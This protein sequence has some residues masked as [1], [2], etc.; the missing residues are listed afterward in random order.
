MLLL[1]DVDEY[2]FAYTG[3][4]DGLVLKG[5]NPAI[6]TTLAVYKKNE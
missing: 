5:H 3:S 4:G 1:A 6:I 2:S